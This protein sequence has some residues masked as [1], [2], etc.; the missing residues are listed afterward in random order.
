[1]MLNKYYTPLSS[2]ILFAKS[3]KVKGSKFSVRLVAL[4]S[5][6]ILFVV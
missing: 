6:V 5:N 2:S 1:M 4:R 3:S